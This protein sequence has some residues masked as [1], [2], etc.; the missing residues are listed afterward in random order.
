MKK[1]WSRGVR[2]LRARDPPLTTLL[3][4]CP[5]CNC[6]KTILFIF[7][8]ISE[9]GKNR[10]GLLPPPYGKFWILSYLY[11]GRHHFEEFSPPAYVVRWE[12]MFS[13]VCVCSGGRGT[14][15]RSQSQV[16]G[17]PHSGP[18][19]GYNILPKGDYTI[20]PN[21]GY[22]QPSQPGVL[23]SSFIDKIGW[24]YPNSQ[25][26]MGVPPS[27]DWGTPSR[28]WWGYPAPPSREWM[29]LGQVMSLAVRLLWFPAGGLSCLSLCWH[30][31]ELW[32]R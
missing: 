4:H 13:Q 12:V 19:V 1:Y 15:A 18:D 3:L 21:E 2:V 17:F 9:N 20:L 14:P 23:T 11:C 10:A 27:Q 6:T 5:I 31:K 32:R 26:W 22:P 28:S 30:R 8:E 24:G 16:K 7:V 29:A 25:H